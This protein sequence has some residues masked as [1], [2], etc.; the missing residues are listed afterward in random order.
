MIADN[1]D[2]YYRQTRDGEPLTRLNQHAVY[3]SAKKKFEKLD[4][5]DEEMDI[6]FIHFVDEI[7]FS[8]DCVQFSFYASVEGWKEYVDR[9]A[10]ESNEDYDAG[11]ETEALFK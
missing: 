7:G 3:Q 4:F 2:Y 10:L 8:C 5:I 9:V 6:N 11:N 1:I